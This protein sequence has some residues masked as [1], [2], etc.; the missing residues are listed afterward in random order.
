MGRFSVPI[1]QAQVTSAQADRVLAYIRNHA[2]AVFYIDEIEVFA[3]AGAKDQ[4]LE[5]EIVE[6][7]TTALGSGG[8]TVTPASGDG[9]GSFGGTAVTIDA[10]GWVTQPTL[11]TVRR[12][13]GANMKAGLLRQF[14]PT[15]ENRCEPGTDR[16]LALR[17]K[18]TPTA[19]ITL[20]GN[21]V[22][23]EA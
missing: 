21:L 16:G 10:D 22:I 7:D 11:T 3:T 2:R 17:I 4:E 20:G 1:A 18:G 13:M 12:K 5:F 23:Y 14:K 19:N 9:S 8:A 15:A 6:L